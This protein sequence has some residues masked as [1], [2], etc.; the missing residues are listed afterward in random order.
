MVWCC[1][2]DRGGLGDDVTFD[3]DEVE[4]QAFSRVGREAHYAVHAV[5]RNHV[6]RPGIAVPGGNLVVPSFWTFGYTRGLN[7]DVDVYGTPRLGVR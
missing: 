7:T 2:A 6:V 4:C 5:E 3:E 1:G